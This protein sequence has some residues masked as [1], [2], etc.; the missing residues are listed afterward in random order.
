[1]LLLCNHNHLCVIICNCYI[2]V[3][4]ILLIHCWQVEDLI[5]LKLLC[6]VLYGYVYENMCLGKNEGCYL[7]I[8]VG[9]LFRVVVLQ[10]V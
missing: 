8:W 7:M 2:F 10:C 9:A 5:Y 6:S 3:T 1:M 4:G